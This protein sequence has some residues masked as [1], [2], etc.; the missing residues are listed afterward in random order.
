MRLWTWA[1][2][3]A[4]A[5]NMPGVGGTPR[6]RGA[7]VGPPHCAT[8]SAAAASAR[9]TSVVARFAANRPSS[10]RPAAATRLTRKLPAAIQET[11]EVVRAL[12][13][14]AEERHDLRRYDFLLLLR[15]V[16]T[17]KYSYVE[18]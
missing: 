15:L 6:S 10:S 3:E 8:A 18:N 16:P 4:A 7:G 11:P 5:A 13:N 1:W 12:F 2:A 14:G 9:V 17:R